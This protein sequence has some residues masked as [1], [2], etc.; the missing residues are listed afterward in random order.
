MKRVLFHFI[1]L[2]EKKVKKGLM[3]FAFYYI[4]INFALANR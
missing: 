1:S 4:V 3:M 2:F